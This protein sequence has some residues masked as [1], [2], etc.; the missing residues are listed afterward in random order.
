[1]A[2]YDG[3]ADLGI[4]LKD[5]V[6]TVEI[7]RPPLNFFDFDLIRQIAGAYEQLDEDDNCRAIVLCSQGKVFCAG[8]NFAARE[9]G[10][11]PTDQAGQLY[12][13]AVRMFRTSKPVVAA[14]QGAAVGGGLGLAVSADF[15]IACAESRFCA[16]FARLG[17]HQGFGLSVTLPRLIGPTQAERMFYT[18]RR[19]KGDEAVALGLAEQFVDKS[20]VRS[21][22]IA[23]ARECAISAP[24]AVREIRKTQRGHLADEVR[25]ATDHEL[26]VQTALKESEDFQ[27]GVRA[28][29]DRREPNFQGR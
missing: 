7:R 18:G 16:N 3:Y 4:E 23:L 2:D 21:A 20:E 6:A 15:R 11:E 28:M 24:L 13:E 27:E 8:A 14:V 9:S 19:V 17:F 5:Y 26:S 25:A 22:A 10:E 1:V 29:S 12:I